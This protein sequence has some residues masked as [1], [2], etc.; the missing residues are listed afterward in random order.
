VLRFIQ[1][2]FLILIRIQG[3]IIIKVFWSSCKVPLIC[4][5]FNEMSI[6]GQILKGNK[7]LNFM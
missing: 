2:N 6:Q 1:E 3:D 7:I 4:S 5:G